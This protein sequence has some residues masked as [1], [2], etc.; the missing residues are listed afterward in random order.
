ME[1]A[2]KLARVATGRS[3]VVAAKRGFH[4]RSY[5]SMSYAGFKSLLY[6]GLSPEDVR[7]RAVFDWIRRHYT[8][9]EN[10]GLGQQGLFYYLHAAARALRVGQQVSITPVDGEARNWR[11]D[12]VE[13]V[14]ERQRPD[15]TWRNDTGRW[16][17]SDPALAT[18]YAVLAL[19]EAI[20]P[21]RFD[22][23]DADESADTSG[24]RTPAKEDRP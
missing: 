14:L 23:E 1:A 2:L 24:V 3:R 5:G 6:A 18:A 22:V 10:P 11:D 17:E 15:G 21:V 9:R 7:V 4:G 19:Q 12:L 8:F 13:A 16:L 20:K